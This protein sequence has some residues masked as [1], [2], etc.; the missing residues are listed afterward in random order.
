MVKRDISARDLGGKED[1]PFLL[2]K[3]E[4]IRIQKYTG[5]GAYLPVNVN[6]MRKALALENTAEL[7]DFGELYTVNTSIKGHCKNWNDTTYREILDVANQI[8]NYSRRAEVF[9]APLL[10]YLPDILEGDTVALEKFQKICEKLAKEAKAFS[11]HAETLAKTVKQFADDTTNDYKNLINVKVKYDALYGKNSEEEIKLRAEVKKLREELEKYIEDYE[12][13]ESESWLSLLLGPVFGFIL[14]GILDSTHGQMLKAK[15]DA[16][17]QKIEATCA[18]IQRNVYL[19][20]LLDKADVGTDK[21][22]K[23]IEEALPVINKIKAIWSALHK[24]LLT[25]STITMKDIHDDPEFA[26]LGIELAIMQWVKVGKQADDFRINAD[27][28][29]ILDQYIA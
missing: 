4:W 29:Y 17:R 24:D 7:P 14:K 1:N 10:D 15:V 28:G 13:Y 11:D 12:D 25:L 20:S 27:V 22:Q 5:D 9:Y 2:K 19:M 18:T 8:V 6:E 23:Q 21:T 3:D 26:D 16:T